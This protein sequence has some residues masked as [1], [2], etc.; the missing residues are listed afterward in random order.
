MSNYFLLSDSVTQLTN[1][2]LYKNIF[3]NYWDWTFRYDI[4]CI[5]EAAMSNI[6]PS[7]ALNVVELEGEGEFLKSHMQRMLH[8]QIPQGL[9][10]GIVH[11]RPHSH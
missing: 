10:V 3:L 7:V 9:T 11:L 8:F 5:H 1:S 2:Y 4:R 6:C